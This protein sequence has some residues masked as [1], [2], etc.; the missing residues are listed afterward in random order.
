M[1]VQGKVQEIRHLAMMLHANPSPPS[2]PPESHSRLKKVFDLTAQNRLT[3]CL[4]LLEDLIA[5]HPDDPSLYND[6]A[7]IKEGL[8]HPDDEIE[9]LFKQAFALD[10]DYLFAIAGLARLAARRGEID[11]AKEM[12]EPLLGHESYHFTEWRSIL[13]TQL[14]MAKQL[15]ELGTALNIQRQIADLQET[16]G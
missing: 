1:L 6:L 14:E 5:D 13:M 11:R 12:I 15:G 4:P 2:L 3:D 9:A 7:S 8:K 16:F 10:P